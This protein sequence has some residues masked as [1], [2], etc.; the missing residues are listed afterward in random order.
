MNELLAII[1]FAFFAERIESKKDFDMIDADSIATNPNDLIEFLF[2]SRH[3]F[4]DIYS[5]YNQFL[6]YG[7]K[8]LY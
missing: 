3:T 1:V 7:V 5:T 4:A 8:N 6:A 2:D